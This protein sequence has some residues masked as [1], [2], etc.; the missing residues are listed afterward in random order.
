M[1]M[2][3][4]T[5][6]GAAVVV[7]ALML[8]L[9]GPYAP[10]NSQAQ[11]KPGGTLTVGLEMEP[12][13]LDPATSNQGAAI[14]LIQQSYSTLFRVDEQLTPVPDLVQEWEA[15]NPSTYI[16]KLRK[17][18]KFHNGRELVAED[19]KY[20][21]DRIMDPK[22]G[23]PY[24]NYFENVAKIETP[25]K[26]TVRLTM[27]NPDASLLTNLT[28]PVTAIVP[29]EEVIRHGDLKIIMVGTG[30]FKWVRWVPN[31]ELVLTKNPDY[32]G[33]D[34]PY[35]DQVRY[36]TL[37]D[38]TARTAALRSGAVDFI[39][40]APAKDISI[41]K[42]LPDVV[43]TDGANLNFVAMALNLK[44]KPFDN[45]K[46]RQA[47]SYAINRDA[48]AAAFDGFARPLFGGPLI[49]PYWA[50]SNFKRYSYDLAMAKKLLAEAGLPN[51]FRSTVLI[52]AGYAV[53]T[54][55]AEAVQGELRR[56]NITLDIVPQEVGIFV[57]N[58][59]EK[60][61]GKF[62]SYMMRFWGIDFI[63]PDGAVYRPFHSKGSYNKIG[64]SN[65]KVD[66]LI[67]KAKRVVDQKERKKL[68]DDLQKILADEAPWIFL[69]SA[70]RSE[71]FKSYVKGYQHL[72]NGAH[73]SF[74]NTWISK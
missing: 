38:D 33:K 22:I 40:N 63:D 50:G 1:N 16:F 43:V 41:L 25:D 70:D 49:P 2:G 42:G 7:G 62:D 31:K 39:E 61:N 36:V 55:A 44:S 53:Y 8:C 58:I 64:Y 52:P 13:N 12:S 71:A 10:F 59:W 11:V 47:M 60:E 56:A 45:V 3:L 14:N 32:F 48:V 73:Y 18:V 23:S 17:G 35:L 24:T 29:K 20:S 26:Y 69:V 74:R 28:M 15:P 51:G 37:F 4:K 72:P 6:G 5:W 68:Y 27:S 54:K 46:V 30:P 65:P 34:L 21:F 9:V 57:A 19:V 66:E 67:E